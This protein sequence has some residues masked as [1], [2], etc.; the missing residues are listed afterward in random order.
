LQ[1][2]ERFEIARDVRNTVK[3]HF[4]P[5]AWQRVA[6]SIFDKLRQRQRD[7]LVAYIM[8]QRGLERLEE[9]FEYF[10]IDPGMEPVVQTSRVRLA[11][12]SVQTFVQR[13]LLN[14]ENQV[15]PSILD[16]A[17]WEWMKRYRVWE[18]NRKIFLFPENWLE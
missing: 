11:I 13:C 17:Q 4:E 6:Q 14:L 12:S 3:A 15:P 7:A 8:H 10:L 5:A 2:E 18:A 1:P 9:L 16:G